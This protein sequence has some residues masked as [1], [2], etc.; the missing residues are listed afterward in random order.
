MKATIKRHNTKKEFYTSE[1]CFITEISNSADDADVSIAQARV[2]AGITTRWHQLEKTVE[3][4][5]IISGEG[6][7]ELGDQAPQDVHP[8]DVIIIPSLCKQRISNT[9]STD[10]IFLAICSPRFSQNNYQELE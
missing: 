5:Y 9:G 4:Y 1:K 3:R 7:M 8:G 2:G 6:R 10:L